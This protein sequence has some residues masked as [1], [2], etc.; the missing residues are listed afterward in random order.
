M[1]RARLLALRLTTYN[2]FLEVAK[3]N[4][5]IPGVH[6]RVNGQTNVIRFYNGSEIIMK[7]LFHY[8]SDPEFDGLGSLEI[9]GAFIDEVNQI[10]PKA[11]DVVMSRIRYKLDEYGITPK[12]FMSCNPAKNWV[13]NDFYKPWSVSPDG[14]KTFVVRGDDGDEK[15]T[16]RR[17]IQALPKDN[18]AFI[19]KHYI[20]NLH[21]LQDKASKK[22]LLFGLWEYSD[23]LS[24]FDFL[25]IH[26]GLSNRRKVRKGARYFMS[27]DVARLGK[28]KTVIAICSETLEVVEIV[29]IAKCKLPVIVERMRKLIA[30]YGID[31]YDV[32]IDS[33]GVGGGV[34][35][36]FENA[37]AIVNGS[38]ALLEQN[39]ANLKTQL[40][41]KLAEVFDD[42]AI[43]FNSI[44]D[45]MA[46]RITEEL[47]VMR[48]EKVEQDGKVFMTS[49]AQIKGLIGRSPDYADALAYLMIF[50]LE[51]L[52]DAYF[53]F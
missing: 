46:A 43:A 17:F 20:A 24:M 7:D 3:A 49:K 9:T 33:D 23:E 51:P 25:K 1:G 14:G 32:A 22:R 19:S 6:F 53:G 4:S 48:R 41:F 12:L 18:E 34:A 15:I 42:G 10:T 31:E 30:K 39:Y 11:K 28:D 50:F 44:S 38:K 16:Y 26:Q 2:T 5:L 13:Y 36:A 40:Y 29:E 21:K 35:D 45:K 37:E 27:V 52:D 47:Q 8:P